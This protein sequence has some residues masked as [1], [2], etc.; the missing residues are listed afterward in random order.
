MTSRSRLHMQGT[1]HFETLGCR[2]NHDES[3]GAARFF[4]KAGFPIDMN[5]LTAAS[6]SSPETVLAV[7]NTCTVTGKAEQKARRLIRLMLQKLPN[8]L[9]VVTGCYAGLDAEAIKAI[10][11]DRICVIPGTSKYILSLLPGEMLPGGSLGIGGERFSHAALESFIGQALLAAGQPSPGHPPAPPS[12]RRKPHP[13]KAFVLYTSVFEKHSRALLK[14]QDG[15]D[16]ACSYCR[17]HLARGAS[18]SLPASEAVRRARELEEAGESEVVLT[19][20]NLGQWRGGGQDPGGIGLLLRALLEGTDRVFFRVSSLYPECVDEKLCEVLSHPRVQPFFHLSIQS[21]SDRVLAAM[22]RPH[23]L[24][25]VESAIRSL[26]RIKENPFISCDI[27]A[28]FPGEGEEEFE[29][30]KLLCE[31]SSFA[32]IHAFPFSPRPGTPAFSMKGQVPDRIKDER[33]SWGRPSRESCPTWGS[34]RAGGSSP[35]QNGAGRRPTGYCT[36]LRAT[37]S[38]SSVLLTALPNLRRRAEAS[39]ASS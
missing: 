8:A 5:P 15:C 3:E 10:S 29:E 11:P 27:I 7:I 26:R 22:R 24:S 28:G 37:S 39:S 31:R 12:P 17:I 9:V 13:V 33:V 14:V 21:G 23:Q 20:V 18:V 2:L 32:W 35:S 6:P 19:G 25:H 4:S 38:M 36:P 16:C 34:G 30:T 1:I